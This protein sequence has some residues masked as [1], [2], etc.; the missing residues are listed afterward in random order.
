VSDEAPELR[1][2]IFDVN[3]SPGL[4]VMTGFF[5]ED[6][7]EVVLVSHDID[8]PIRRG[9][10]SSS[11]QYFGANWTCA[12]TDIKV[13]CASVQVAVIVGSGSL[14]LSSA[15]GRPREHDRKTR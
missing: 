8:D 14:P 10:R 4:A 13:E 9:R 6:L 7:E 11:G 5:C 15:I 3:I 1:N 2:V 12:Y